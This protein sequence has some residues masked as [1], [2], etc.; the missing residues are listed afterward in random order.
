MPS[1]YPQKL[2]N[3]LFN[4]YIIAKATLKLELAYYS[5]KFDT[6]FALI[7][8]C[9]TAT[10]QQAYMGITIHYIDKNWQLQSNLLDMVELNSSHS[11]LYLFQKL[12]ASLIDFNIENRI[13]R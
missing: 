2:N 13:I 11:G 7:T 6:R 1:L 9:W 8:D 3:N 10:N 4:F 5:E 12:T